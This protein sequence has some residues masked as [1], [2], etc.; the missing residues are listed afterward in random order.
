MWQQLILKIW[1]KIITIAK[2]GAKLVRDSRQKSV[3]LRN[4]VE[5]KDSKPGHRA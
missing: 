2:E 1:M 3:C 5:K 4:G